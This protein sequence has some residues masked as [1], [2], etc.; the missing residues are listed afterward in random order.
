MKTTLFNTETKK[1]R[2]AIGTN[3]GGYVAADVTAVGAGI[4]ITGKSGVKQITVSLES[5]H[6]IAGLIEALEELEEKFPQIARLR[7]NNK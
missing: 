5:I 6:E 7:F 3:P 2:L 4:L 1:T